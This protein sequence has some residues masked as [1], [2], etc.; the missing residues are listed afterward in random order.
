VVSVRTLLLLV[1]SI[2][3]VQG[4]KANS[5]VCM[6][7]AP[8]VVTVTCG[9]TFSANDFLNW[10]APVSAGGLGEATIPGAV[11]GQSIQVTTTGGLGINVLSKQTLERADN[12]TYAWD[13]ATSSWVFPA[14]LGDS[15]QTFSGQ[16]NAPSEPTYTGSS[17]PAYGP[18][19]YPY[20]FG[21][22]LL[23]AVPPGNIMPSEMQFDFSKSIFGIA[24]KISSA[25]ATNFVATLS[26]YNSA[27]QLI[28]TYQLNTNGAG[29]GGTCS[30]LSNSSGPVPCND[31]PVIQF[32]DPQGHIAS[33][34]LTVNDMNGFFVDGLSIN[35]TGAP[36]PATIPLIG[37]GLIALALAAKT[38]LRK[39]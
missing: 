12:T 31:A 37:G 13:A 8:S 21:D 22:P 4:L 18:N 33:V 14:V 10:G 9:Q 17:G 5:A 16:F 27:M 28:G 36:E 32:Y 2:V 1:L 29:G 6:M 35:T 26:A 7:T 19:N 30:S 24:F 20:Q 23:G 15:I 39:Q 34:I 25:Q 38:R 11:L 3:N